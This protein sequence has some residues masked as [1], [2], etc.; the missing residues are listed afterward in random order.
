MGALLALLRGGGANEEPPIDVNVDLEAA[1]PTPDENQLFAYASESLNATQYLLDLLRGYQGCGDAIRKAISNPSRETE[2]AA[3]NVVS[4]AVSTLKDFYTFSQK[5]ED[6]L[7]RLLVFLCNGNVIQN[8]EA[9]QATARRLADLLHFTSTFDELKMS[10]P[11]IQNDFSYYRRT[12][13]RMRMA[14]IATNNLV[15][16]D[17]LANRM[18]L[19]YA[20]S[21]PMAK[22]VI[23]SAQNLVRRNEVN[24]EGLTDCLA[25]LAAVCYNAAVKGRAQGAMV[26]YCLRVMTMCIIVYDHVAPI[27]A[28]AKGTKV[29]VRASVKAIQTLGGSGSQSLLNSLRYSTV[30]LNDETTPK[31]VKQILAV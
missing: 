24:A 17:E 28:F 16:H 2:E 7:P 30:H 10:N 14:N 25:I 4:P 26:E 8:L 27:G 22:C 19:F 31:N 29:N 11:N 6:L 9:H 15:V 21:S 3:W 1:R 20:H 13:S 5:I 23:D 12:L 18:S